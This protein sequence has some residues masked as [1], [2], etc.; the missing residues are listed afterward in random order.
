M[1]DGKGDP[2]GALRYR[3]VHS[4]SEKYSFS[5]SDPDL[6]PSPRADAIARGLPNGDGFFTVNSPRMG[7]FLPRD[8]LPPEEMAMC[9]SLGAGWLYIAVAASTVEAPMINVGVT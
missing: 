6:S 5:T 4:I 9:V 1:R 7:S 2:Y 3:D 8:R